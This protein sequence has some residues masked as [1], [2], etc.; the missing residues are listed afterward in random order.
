MKC[1]SL[2][3]RWPRYWGGRQVISHRRRRQRLGVERFP[4]FLHRPLRLQTIYRGAI[5]PE[6]AGNFRNGF[7]SRDPVH[8]LA[9]L[10]RGELLRPPE[11]HAARLGAF[12]AL[13]GAGADKCSLELGEPAQDGGR[14]PTDNAR[15]LQPRLDQPRPFFFSR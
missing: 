11:P 15:A 1:C 8:C 9:P 12:A 10:V 7:S 14:R 6:R 3:E 4:G 13:A 5:H 2:L